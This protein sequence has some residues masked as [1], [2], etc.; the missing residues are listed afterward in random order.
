MQAKIVWIPLA[1]G[2]LR[3]ADEGYYDLCLQQGKSEQERA[4]WC[5][6][7]ADYVEENWQRLLE[8][9]EGWSDSNKRACIED[10]WKQVLRLLRQEFAFWSKT[11]RNSNSA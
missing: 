10:G 9:T 4:I 6:V 8:S 1:G 2:E 5:G 7:A 3:V 11:E